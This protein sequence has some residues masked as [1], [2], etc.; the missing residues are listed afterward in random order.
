M[1]SEKEDEIIKIAHETVS[2]H[3]NDMKRQNILK[4]LAIQ[5]TAKTKRTLV[6]LYMYY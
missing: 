1:T 5:N 4:K 6:L 3:S 2:K